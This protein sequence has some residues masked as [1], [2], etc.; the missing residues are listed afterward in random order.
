[1][2]GNHRVN[3]I[4]EFA[5]ARLNDE[6]FIV[7][8][9][10]FSTLDARNA[11][12]SSDASLRPI[13]GATTLGSLTST[14]YAG[15]TLPATR[16]IVT[17]EGVIPRRFDFTGVQNAQFVILHEIQHGQGIASEADAN[18]RALLEMRR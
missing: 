16:N 4:N 8:T 2:I 11:A 9:Q 17:V 1:K 14:V 13:N 10:T 15:A 12:M 6:G 5:L 7:S 3:F 18:R